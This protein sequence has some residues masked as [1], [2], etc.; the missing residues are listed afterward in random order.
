MAKGL[1]CDENEKA[2]NEKLSKRIK[3]KPAKDD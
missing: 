3:E 2:F 1:E